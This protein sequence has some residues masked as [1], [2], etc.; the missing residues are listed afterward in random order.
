MKTLVTGAAGFIGFHVSKKLAESGQKVI[1]I[2]NLNDYYDV[3]LKYARL[4][5]LNNLPFFSFE[6]ANIADQGSMEKIFSANRDITQVIHLAAQAGVRYSLINP[7]AYQHANLQGLL[8]LLELTRNLTNLE[9]FIFASSSSVYGNLQKLPYSTKDDTNKPISFYGA[10]KKSGEV[11]CHSYSHIYGMPMTC[12]RLFTVYGPW[13]RPDMAAYL[14]TQQILA[15]SSI[16]V[17]NN[18]HMRRDFTYIEDCVAGVVTCV[19]KGPEKFYDE[20]PFAVF[21]IGNSQSESLMDFIKI[22]EREVGR[23]A[24]IKFMPLQ[25]GDVV[26]TYADIEETKNAFGFDPKTN[27]SEGLINFIGWYRDYHEV[28][29]FKNNN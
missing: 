3:A 20:A 8:V 13:G 5:Q 28:L 18:G 19:F 15:G 22:I 29:R 4:D 21:N 6:K 2:D 14:F 7:H 26:E 23:E 1:G 25:K 17:F 16:N 24:D 12:L 9:H 11:I 27:I 10:T